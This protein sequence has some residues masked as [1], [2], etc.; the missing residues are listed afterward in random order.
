MTH[1]RKII[2]TNSVDYHSQAVYYYLQVT[3][4][5]LS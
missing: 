1:V 4:M 2:R 5:K 3:S